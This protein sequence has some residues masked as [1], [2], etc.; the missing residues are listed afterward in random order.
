MWATYAVS[1]GEI[2]VAEFPDGFFT[3]PGMVEVAM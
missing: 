2:S 1:R 3:Q